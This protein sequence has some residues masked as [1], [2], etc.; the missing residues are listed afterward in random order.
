[1]NPDDVPWKLRYIVVQIENLKMQAKGWS[2]SR[3]LR[4]ANSDT[5]IVAK[6]G[7]DRLDD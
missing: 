3:T 5:D 1:M 4:E 2:I 6:N 7:V